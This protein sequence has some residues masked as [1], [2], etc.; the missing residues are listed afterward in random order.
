[1]TGDELGIAAVDV[2]T[3]SNSYGGAILATKLAFCLGGWV[4]Y[5]TAGGLFDR[6]N[7]DIWN[8]AVTF[9]D[10]NLLGFRRRGAES[11]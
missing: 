9:P 3:T 8:Y 6:G 5:C 10:L 11:H 7:L 2:P 4:G 1:M